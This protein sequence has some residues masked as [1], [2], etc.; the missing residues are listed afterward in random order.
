MLISVSISVSIHNVSGI[1]FGG[2]R[3]TLLPISIYLVAVLGPTLRMC[4]F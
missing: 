4:Y 1:A 3:E 2:K